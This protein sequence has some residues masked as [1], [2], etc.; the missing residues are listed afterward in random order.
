MLC[1][2][3][4]LVAVFAA[5]MEIAVA[6]EAQVGIV[7][8]LRAKGAEVLPLGALGGLDG[9]MVTL[10][11]GEVYS[12][13][14][15]ADGHGVA[16]LLYGPDGAMITGRQLAAAR[17]AERIVREAD[18][19]PAAS[20]QDRTVARENRAAV[21]DK[22]PAARASPVPGAALSDAAALFEQTAAAFGFTIFG[23]GGV[24]GEN[25][26]LLATVFA[27]PQCPWSRTVVARLGEA[28]LGGRLRL[29]VVPV[30]LLGAESARRAAGIASSG[31]PVL[32]WF[33]KTPPLMTS[34]GRARIERNN[35]IYGAWGV[36]VVPLTVWQ[37]A[38]GGVGRLVGDIA[39]I[40]AWLMEVRR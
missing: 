13:Y 35:A 9:Y 40:E 18:V 34:A 16:G 5:D 39:D 3:S 31:D 29:R 6:A 36:R 4:V 21:D 15:T 1:R 38:D 17:G 20:S 27:D 11:S 37:T 28:A 30:A 19:P 24:P 14:V 10:K 22:T 32:A 26:P 2:A 8:A 25:E 23:M 12:L 7:A 33:S